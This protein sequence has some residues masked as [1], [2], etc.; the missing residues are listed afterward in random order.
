MKWLGYVDGQL[1][2]LVAMLLLAYPEGTEQ[3]RRARWAVIRLRVLF[4]KLR[5]ALAVAPMNP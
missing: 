2:H 3:H 4:D 1:E 5:T